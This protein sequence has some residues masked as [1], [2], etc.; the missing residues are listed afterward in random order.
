MIKNEK[1][2]ASEV[3]LTGL[4]GEDLGTMPTKE[5][6]ALAKQLKVDLI[7][8]SL[9]SSPPPCKLI[10]SGQAKQE[11]LQE[12]QQARKKDQPLKVKELRLTPHI[13]DHDLDTKRQQAERILKA[14]DAVMLVV[15]I[16]GKEGAK[17]KE[18]LENLVKD[19]SASGRKQTG[20]QLS[21]KQAAVQLDPL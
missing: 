20:I 19:L 16:S 6:L 18:L 12:K 5:A 8:T 15:K 7:C 17:A 3:H 9:M 21:G 11:A 1:I 10:G 4:H 13:E 14:G 2:K